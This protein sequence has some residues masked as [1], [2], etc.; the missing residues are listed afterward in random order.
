MQEQVIKVYKSNA[1]YLRRNDLTP[2]MRQTIN[3]RYVVRFYNE[4]VCAK[5]E[6][7]ED[8]HTE[9]FCDPCAAFTDQV[10][11]SGE[12]K[13]GNQTY[14]KAPLGDERQL[15][16]WLSGKG[17]ELD[18]IDKQPEHKKYPLKFLGELRDYQLH[19]PKE[20][21][22]AKRG[23]LKAPPRTGKTVMFTNVACR[24]RGKTIIIA[25]QKDWLDGFYDTFVGSE[26]TKRMSNVPKSRIGFCTTL[27]DFKKNV[28]CLVTYHTFMHHP[29]LLQQVKSMFTTALY[30]EVHT[31]AAYEFLKVVG[32]INARYTFGCSGTPSRKD[33]RFKLTEMVLGK[34]VSRAKREV[35][36]C[37]VKLN[38]TT[39][40]DSRD[41]GLWPTLV[42]RLETDPNRLRYIAETAV[43][44]VKDGHCVLIPLAGVVAQK[45]LVEAINKIA[46]KK[47][48]F[49][50]TGSMKKTDRR[51]LILD[52][53]LGK[54]PCIVGTMK[55]ISTGLNIPPAS[56]LYEVTPSANPEN[57]T[58]RVSR[59]LTPHE[60][61][62]DPILRIFLDDYGVR[63]NC[64]RSE[65][66]STIKPVFKPNVSEKDTQILKDYFAGNDKSMFA[67][68][69]RKKGMATT[70]VNSATGHSGKSNNL[71]GW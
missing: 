71:L 61:K 11:L 53:Q 30:D 10:N 9:E 4:K 67:G 36:T 1:L 44:D 51:Q 54:I 64:L 69:Q 45:A 28:I 41:K 26:L 65:W 24:I 42:K 63:R 21:I 17:Y 70:R 3:E 18:V 56:A 32:T 29:K 68:K 40:S 31:T 49:N 39:F 52:A 7:F 15:M 14:V 43:K 5:C 22:I 66:F 60:G 6:H 55:M 33:G 58:Q 57:C 47:I 12:Y 23:I 59:I 16:A 19:V 48:A 20:L 8:R 35:M 38:R 2:K 46:G 27:A 37:T 34:I 50:F 62:P 25:S 13:I